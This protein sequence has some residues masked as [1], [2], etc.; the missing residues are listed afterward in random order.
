MGLSSGSAGVQQGW[1]RQGSSGHGVEKGLSRGSAGCADDEQMLCRCCADVVQMLCRCR[2]D[3][4]QMSS[5]CC[6]NVGHMMSRSQADVEQMLRRCCADVARRLLPVPFLA[7][8][9]AHPARAH[10]TSTRGGWELRQNKH[11][12]KNIKA[13]GRPNITT[14]ETV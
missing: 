14:I 13:P 12:L 4:V 7:H 3:V 9:H 1:S 2:A 5:R 6:A 8:L 10:P 11:L